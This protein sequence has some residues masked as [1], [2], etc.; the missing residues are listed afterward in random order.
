MSG[1]EA[2]K[3]A[4]IAGLGVAFVSRFAIAL[5]LAQ[6]LVSV[7]EILELHFSRQLFLIARKEARPSAASLAFLALMRKGEARQ[8]PL[9]Q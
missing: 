2:V 1:C 6:K 4:V 3:R 8:G 5:E 7:P 9:D